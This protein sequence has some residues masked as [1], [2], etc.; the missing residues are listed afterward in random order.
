MR[1]AMVKKSSL[2]YFNLRAVSSSFLFL[3]F[4]TSAWA[5]AHLSV[6]S[7]SCVSVLE[8][9]EPHVIVNPEGARTTPSVV[10]IKNDSL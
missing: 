1:P 8:G 4:M 9:G 7:D 6:S 3:K 2:Q 10:L 5:L